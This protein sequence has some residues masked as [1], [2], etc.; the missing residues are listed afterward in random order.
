MIFLGATR[1]KDR[2]EERSASLSRSGGQATA[3]V[4]LLLVHPNAVL[5]A[6]ASLYDYVYDDH[7]YK[8]VHVCACSLQMAT[9]SM[10]YTLVRGT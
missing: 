1:G 7:T 9:L 5:A 8:Y 10:Y 4:L 3:F 6:N 2:A